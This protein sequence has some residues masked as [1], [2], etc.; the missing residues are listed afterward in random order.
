M[1]KIIRGTRDARGTVVLKGGQGGLRK[2][3]CSSCQGYAV[4][5]T[6]PDGTRAYKCTCG[7]MYKATPM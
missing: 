3:R 1:P 6:L 2:V 7:A 4:E 5:T